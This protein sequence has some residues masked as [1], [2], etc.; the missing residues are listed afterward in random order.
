MFSNFVECHKNA[1]N[2][3]ESWNPGYQWAAHLRRQATRYAMRQSTFEPDVE[4]RRR[5]A[6]LEAIRQQQLYERERAYREKVKKAQHTLEQQRRRVVSKQRQVASNGGDRDQA[7]ERKLA[8]RR[9]ARQSEQP[10]L[11]PNVTR[12]QAEWA[13]QQEAAA[14]AQRAQNLRAFQAH[15]EQEQRLQAEQAQRLQAEQK[16]RTQALEDLRTQAFC[17]KQAMAQHV[18][19][20]VQKHDAAVTEY[21]EQRRLNPNKKKTPI[22]NRQL[23]VYRPQPSLVSRTRLI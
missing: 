2:I 21:M 20:E 9:N 6:Q 12:T 4:R 11:Q 19:C 18:H 1:L 8:A 3:A 22:N 5:D 7:R 23:V 10:T 13:R 15:A 16:L 17:Q 14:A